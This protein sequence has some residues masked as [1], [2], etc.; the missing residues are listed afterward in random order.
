MIRLIAS[1]VAALF[2]KHYNS[3]EL[4]RARW[5]TLSR[6]IPLLYFAWF[7]RHPAPPAAESTD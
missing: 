3:P 7:S 6:M 2:P 4:L 5:D 1:R